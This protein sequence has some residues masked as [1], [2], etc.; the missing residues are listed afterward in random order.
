MEGERFFAF[1]PAREEGSKQDAFDYDFWEAENIGYWHGS[2]SFLMENSFL[3]YAY[4]I[5]D[6]LPFQGLPDWISRTDA[7]DSCTPY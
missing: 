7:G 5:P 2:C 1:H 3:P 4:Y 6:I